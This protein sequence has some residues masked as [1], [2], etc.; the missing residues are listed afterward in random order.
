MP[1]FTHTVEYLFPEI[2][3]KWLQFANHQ[4]WVQN[5]ILVGSDTQVDSKCGKSFFLSNEANS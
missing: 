4:V 2:P 1:S 5:Q 3:F